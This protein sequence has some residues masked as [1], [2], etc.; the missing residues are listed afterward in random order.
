MFADYYRR[1]RELV[2]VKRP[3]DALNASEADKQRK[4]EALTAEIDTIDAAALQPR[5]QDAAGAQD[6]H[7]P[8]P[9]HFGGH[10]RRPFGAG[11]DEDGEQAGAAD[12][13]GGAV[14][15]LQNRHGSTNRWLPCPSGWTILYY[16]ARELATELADRLTPTAL[17]P[18]SWT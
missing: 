5:G 14:D 1:Y 15:G 3:L 13:L 11:R 6:R 8:R 12:F 7:H 18:G 10:H 2:T 9:G 16:S 4:I 17:T